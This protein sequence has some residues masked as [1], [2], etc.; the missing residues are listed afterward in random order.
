[1]IAG[2]PCSR[3]VTQMSQLWRESAYMVHFYFAVRY[4]QLYPFCM[5][6]LHGKNTCKI[7]AVKLELVTILSLLGSWCVLLF[8]FCLA[9]PLRC[10]GVCVMI[11]PNFT[12]VQWRTM[13][14][15][16]GL[17]WSGFKRKQISIWKGGFEESKG[18]SD[19]KFYF[20]HRCIILWVW[21]LVFQGPC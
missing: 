18:R 20:K 15:R 2:N 12:Y 6:F 3:V 4:L 8:F 9:F 13:R 11:C 14:T 16:A 17:V 10:S 5:F 1:M 19:E 21:Q 7:Q